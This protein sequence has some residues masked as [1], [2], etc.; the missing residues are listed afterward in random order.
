MAMIVCSECD[1]TIEHFKAD[2]MAT[3]YGNCEACKK[4]RA[5]K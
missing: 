2:K 1:C 5:S 4:K 3:L